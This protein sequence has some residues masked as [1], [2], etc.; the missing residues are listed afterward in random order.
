MYMYIYIYIYRMIY[1]FGYVNNKIYLPA[2][3]STAVAGVKT[4][5]G[6]HA[7]HGVQMCSTMNNL[8]TP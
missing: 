6:G 5:Y 8:V 1:I 3:A 4:V 7:L 2:R